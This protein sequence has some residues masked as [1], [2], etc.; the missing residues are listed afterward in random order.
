MCAIFALVYTVLDLYAFFIIVHV[1]L[2]WLVAFRIINT[3][4][5]FVQMVWD[6]LRRLVDPACQS[7]RSLLPPIGG[8]DLSPLV[9][10]LMVY[11]VQRILVDT[12]GPCVLY[13]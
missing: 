8:I 2:S 4:N 9:L 3:T 6:F 12:F 10:L 5:N 11:F 7:I 1:I 13:L